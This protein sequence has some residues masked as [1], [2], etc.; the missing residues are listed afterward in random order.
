MSSVAPAIG[1][2][3]RVPAQYLPMEWAIVALLI[4]TVLVLTVVSQSLLTAVNVHYAGNG[5]AFYEKV[6]PATYLVLATFAVLLL[7]RGDPIREIDRI[8]T[9]AKLLMG[10]LFCWGLLVLQCLILHRPVAGAIDTFLLPVLFAVTVWNL[11]A[12]QR[13][14][15]AW[16][17][18]A[19][20]WLNIAA[21]YYEYFSGH[22]VVPLTVGGVPI[23]GEW[24]ST[25]F[26]GSPLAASSVIALYT[27]TLILRP[28]IFPLALMRIPAIVVSLGSLMVFGGRTALISTLVVL[29]RPSTPTSRRSSPR[30]SAV[31]APV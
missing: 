26:L 1:G 8:A 4:I 14:P 18:H 16:V 7:R 9:H 25:A 20:I 17:L 29:G 19:F 11:T 27:L 2:R 30:S 23:Y 21:G 24:R 6:H 5:G 22:R 3:A 15:L 13:R 28:A 31:A 10:F 12:Q